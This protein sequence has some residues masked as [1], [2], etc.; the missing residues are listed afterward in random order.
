VVAAEK[1]EAVVPVVLVEA[2][3]RLDLAGQVG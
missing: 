3:D 2:A 1:V